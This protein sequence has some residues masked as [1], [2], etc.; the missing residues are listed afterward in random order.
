[1]VPAEIGGVFIALTPL[2]I[3]F[4][5]CLPTSDGAAALVDIVIPKSFDL[6]STVL[7]T[8]GTLRHMFSPTTV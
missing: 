1:M 8:P 2:H 4:L 7:L 6:L 5:G 3:H